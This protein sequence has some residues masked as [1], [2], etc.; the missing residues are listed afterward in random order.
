MRIPARLRLG[1]LLVCCTG[2]GSAESSRFEMSFTPEVGDIVRVEETVTSTDPRM[3]LNWHTIYEF[4][5]RGVVEEPPD[6]VRI[7][8][9]RAA[10]DLGKVSGSDPPPDQIALASRS[11]LLR[12]VEGE[13]QSTLIGPAPTPEQE[14][15]IS[16][17]KQTFSDNLLYSIK[18]EP[19]VI[20]EEWTVRSPEFRI[21]WWFGTNFTGTY[22]CRFTDYMT[23][24]GQPCG[25]IALR[26]EMALEDVDSETSQTATSELNLDGHLFIALPAAHPVH[27]TAVGSLTVK[28]LDASGVTQEEESFPVTVTRRWQLMRD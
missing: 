20:G 22:H 7:A 24:Q 6:A 10:A 23:Y 25:V 27:L 17:L 5:F 21:G 13:I 4:D 3:G 12:S 11:V 26:C 28:V 19:A 8:F 14:E 16:G 9:F 1:L 18:P 2:C 15:E